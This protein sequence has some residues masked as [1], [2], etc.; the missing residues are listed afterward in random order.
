MELD[1]VSMKPNRKVCGK[2][3]GHTSPAVEDLYQTLHHLS[4]IYSSNSKLVEI[5]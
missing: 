3:G 4:R 5:F 1:L 2:K